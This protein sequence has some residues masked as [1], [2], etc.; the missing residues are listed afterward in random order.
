M[1]DD[2]EKTCVICNE[3]FTGWGNNP[4]PIKDKGECC[5]NCDME[6]VIPARIQG[7]KKTYEK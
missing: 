6:K 4:S 5:D 1:T 3:K 7:I 2:I